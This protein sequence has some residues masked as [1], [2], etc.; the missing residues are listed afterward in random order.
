MILMHKTANHLSSI[1]RC[2][3]LTLLS[4]VMHFAHADEP[5]TWVA[6]GSL[7]NFGYR[8]LGDN[9]KL[10]DREDGILPGLKLGLRKPADQWLF[11][12][13]FALHGGDVAYT[14]HTQTGIPINT[15][16]TQNILDTTIQ[17]E[18]WTQNGKGIAYAP[19]IGGGY[20][21]WRRDIQPTSTASGAPVRGLLEI[22]TWWVGFIGLKT[23][24]HQT[25]TSHWLV[26]ARLVQIIS[27][28][29]YIDFGGQYDNATLLLGERLGIR[30]A[31]PWRSELDETSHLLIEPYAEY[32]ELG[33]SANAPL[34][35][36]G[37][38]VGS[39]YEPY[40][41]TFNYGLTVGIAQKF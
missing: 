40:S 33:R 9:D 29:I 17:A 16:T 38:A 12:A 25:D 36:N 20:H 1:A 15:R 30:L 23:G 21:Y 26:D 7:L 4:A 6:S 10:L 3:F 22:Y 39:V 35:S 19:Y 37:S 18:Y 24:L 13:D 27:P 2:I 34:T 8:E 14:G 41:Q 11:A 28:S 5:A 31:L 32:F